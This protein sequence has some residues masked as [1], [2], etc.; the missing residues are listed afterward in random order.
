VLSRG[1]SLL[2]VV[3]TQSAE[4]NVLVPAEKGKKC[5]RVDF[6]PQVRHGSCGS[7]VDGGFA[8]KATDYPVLLSISD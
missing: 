3:W 1:N 8:A 5:T 4:Q 2:H 7:P 6:F